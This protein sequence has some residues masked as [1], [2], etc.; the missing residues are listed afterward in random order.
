MDSQR[1]HWKMRTVRLDHF[2]E[3]TRSTIATFTALNLIANISGPQSSLLCS[4][5]QPY[6]HISYWRHVTMVF[7]DTL[8]LGTMRKRH[9]MSGNLLIGSVSTVQQHVRSLSDC[10][11]AGWE[12]HD[13]KMSHVTQIFGQKLGCKP[14]CICP[15]F[16]CFGFVVVM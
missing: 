5:N 8:S 9:R 1:T 13:S 16:I 7:S 11:M 10:P 3:R 6:E 4:C 2:A 12:Q 15:A 14:E